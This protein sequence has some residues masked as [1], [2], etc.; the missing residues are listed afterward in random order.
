MSLQ[1][2]YVTFNMHYKFQC[3]PPCGGIESNQYL[4]LATN[5]YWSIACV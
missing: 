5:K 4:I 1:L 3:Q 2:S